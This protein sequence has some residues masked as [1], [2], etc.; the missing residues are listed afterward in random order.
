VR[1]VEATL[2]RFSGELPEPIGNA[3]T[4][5]RTR[6]GLLLTLI[7][8]EGRAGQG[9]CAPLPGYSPDEE[10]ACRE[11]LEAL[12][13]DEL[14]HRQSGATLLEG[15]A[16]A[17]S[18]LPQ[19]LPAA[20]FAIET[21]LLDLAGQRAGRPAWRL[22]RSSVR[23]L[24]S[25]PLPVSLCGVVVAPGRRPDDVLGAASRLVERGLSRLKLKVGYEGDVE[26]ARALRVHLPEGVLL[27][28]DANRAW[29]EQEAPERLAGLAAL[30]PEL[31][32]EPSEALE[33]LQ[34]P[35]VPL[36]LDESLQTPGPLERLRPALRRLRV[37]A[38]VLKPTALGG[39]VR[40]IELATRAQ[41][42]GLG[43][44]VSHLFD[45]PVALGSAAALA[46]AVASPERASGL[47]R[48]PGLAIWPAVSIPIV[49]DTHILPDEH[50]GLGIEP[51]VGHRASR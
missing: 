19:E 8:E 27:R 15:L 22:L 23:R 1:I 4:G 11:A 44:I 35:P 28:F 3:R 26:L 25:R 33:A 48:H 29:S 38:V 45:G 10:E 16:A 51:L 31:V 36:A 20:R 49:G 43:V 5:W 24:D 18:C 34:S 7:D 13:W 42:L 12:D 6:S 9:E 41:S 39:L 40:C 47:D 37:E 2:Q 30:V 14:V 21:A 46:L 17:S 32:E 50:P